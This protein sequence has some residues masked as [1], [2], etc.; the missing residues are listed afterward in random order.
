MEPLF[1]LDVG[2]RKVCGVL[3]EPGPQGPVVAHAVVREHPGRAM[4]DGQV[5][6]IEAAGRVIAQVRQELQM[7][8]DDP[9][10]AG[11]AYC[12][13]Y[14][15][16]SQKLDSQPMLKLEGH[17]GEIVELEV[18]ATFLPRLAL[19]AL[20]AALRSA[21]L[22]AASLTLEPIAAV[23]LAVPPELRRLNLG[24][25]DIGAGTSDIALTRDGR[26]DAYAMV[27]VAGDEV[28]ERICDAFLLDF[29]QGEKLKRDSAVGGLVPVQ[30]L[31]GAHRLIASADV[32]RES[33]PAI[34]WWAA[35]VAASLI[36]LNGG[37]APQAVLLAGGGSQSPGMEKALA[38]ALG[39]PSSRVGRRPT[40]LQTYFATLPKELEEPWAV[41]PLGIAASAWDKRGLPFAQFQVNG[42]WVQALNLNQ[43][44]SAFDA[45]VASGK[46]MAQF[47]GRP[48]LATSYTFNGSL[49][50]ERGGL[51]Q[52]CK[53]YVNGAEA[54]LD[55]ELH[56]GDS[57]TFMDA[58]SGQDGLLSYND[59]LAKEGLGSGS[60][61]F[62]GEERPLPL[63]LMQEGVAVT[64]L[65]APLPDRARLEVQ[66]SATLEQLLNQEG[67]DLGGMIARDIAVTLDGEP[68]L[69]AQRNYRLQLDG[70]EAPLESLV[71]P[72]AEVVFEPGAG[73]QERI[74][75]LLALSDPLAEAR[76]AHEKGAWRVRL[77]GEWAPL[78]KTERV[79]MNDRE[80]SLDEFL[81]DGASIEI[82]RGKPCATVAEALK[83]LG[84]EAWLDGGRLQISLNGLVVEGGEAIQDGDALDLSLKEGAAHGVKNA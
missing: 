70:R 51:G 25:V 1:A 80:V 14:N 47:Y 36:K 78:D 39:V 52:P 75:D 50:T 44:F 46:E 43:R 59:A 31:F 53:L 49:R 2:T 33:V 55:A 22:S 8:L 21:G 40:R 82:Q 54:T 81:I 7:A 83:R 18:L 60:I 3:L 79:L 67:V 24:F 20:Q 71:L 72:G 4:L 19:D 61:K 58:V 74:R 16:L 35:Q 42:Q 17:R 66:P 57:L 9:R 12:V 56:N 76:R 37:Q 63:T 32:W 45:L 6:H 34:N 30:D 26:V 15:L 41:T 10:S 69:L 65:D 38:D 48:G 23:Q 62:N 5:H 11:G 68:R 84:L 27:D 28:T 73:F 13:G 29:N 77:N 64:D